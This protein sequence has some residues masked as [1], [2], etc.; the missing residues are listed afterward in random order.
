MK[1]SPTTFGAWSVCL[2]AILT[3]GQLTYCDEP[4]AQKSDGDR[5]HEFAVQESASYEI[6]I[7]GHDAPLTQAAEPVLRWSN[8]VRNRT[9]GETYI[10]TKDGCAR[11]IISIYAIVSGKLISAECQSLSEDPL[12]TNRNGKK[13]WAPET[14]GV[15]FRELPNVPPPAANPRTRLL[16]LNRIARQFRAEFAPHTAPEEFNR[17]RLLPKPLFRYDSTDSTII[18]G[19]VYGFVES[20]DP[21]VLLIIEARVDKDGRRFWVYSPARSRHDHLK[22]FLKNNLV[23]EVEQLAPPWQNIRDPAKPYFGCR[24]DRLMTVDE[25]ETVLGPSSD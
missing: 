2:G 17:L 12:T 9:F 19:G 15:E 3:C 25:V 13:L 24:L 5:V 8:V 18:D 22:V 23:W 10:W 7:E 11:A 1:I 6:K 14:P 21:E 16:Q 20:T 4:T